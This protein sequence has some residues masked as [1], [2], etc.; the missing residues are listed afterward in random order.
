MRKALTPREIEIAMKVAAGR[1]NKQIAEELK[2]SARTVEGHRSRLM[3]K[4]GLSTLSLQFAPRA[5]AFDRVSFQH[6]LQAIK[7]PLNARRF[8]HGDPCRCLPPARQSS[9]EIH[10]DWPS[11][12]P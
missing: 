7:S 12:R 8:T 1:S 4:L 11:P 9:Y 6:Y 3:M 2:L 5:L 10:H